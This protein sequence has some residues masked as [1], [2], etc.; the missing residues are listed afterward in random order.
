MAVDCIAHMKSRILAILSLV[1]VSLAAAADGYR[2]ESCA[3]AHTIWVVPLLVLFI[4]GFFG[5]FGG[6]LA[7][8]G[9]VPVADIFTRG[10]LGTYK[11]FK[12]F[13]A[14]TAL[15]A[16]WGAGGGLVFG[17][18]LFLDGK[19]RSLTLA[20]LKNSSGEEFIFFACASVAAGFSGIRLLR[21]VS[22]KLEDQVRNAEAQAA[23]AVKLSEANE[24]AIQRVTKLASALSY[25]GPLL[26]S[27]SLA[28]KKFEEAETARTGSP[29]TKLRDLTDS[30]TAAV[31]LALEMLDEA[32]PGFPTLRLLGIYIGRLHKALKA[33]PKAIEALTLVY[34]SRSDPRNKDDAALLF[35]RA[36][37]RNRLSQEPS[38]FKADLLK[39]EA[40]ADLDESI[41]LDP[42]SATEALRDNELRGLK[43]GP[44]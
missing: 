36:C 21:L 5:A 20:T 3:S 1:V 24:I 12:R 41:R 42:Q 44:Q 34:K 43:G 15:G 19:F 22:G 23:E 37:Y 40:Q 6:M 32:R 39:A 26:D 35:N 30:E 10:F 17:V 11:S 33:Y 28:Q 38:D 13:F 14:I 25:A 8:W 9:H 4:L 7:A 31:R 16:L 29:T 2:D 27:L 18:I